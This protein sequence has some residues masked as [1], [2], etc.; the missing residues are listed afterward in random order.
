MAAAPP[1]EEPP[2]SRPRL[3]RIMSL[4]EAPEVPARPVAGGGTF[5][6]ASTSASAWSGTSITLS[7]APAVRSRSP[8]PSRRSLP[9]TILTLSSGGP[10]SRVIEVVTNL[11][12]LHSGAVMAQPPVSS[13]SSEEEID[14]LVEGSFVHSKGPSSSSNVDRKDSS[15]GLV[16]TGGGR[17]GRII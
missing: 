14:Q 1:K 2:C 9:P 13:A 6:K 3:T 8:V 4:E 5:R 17:M 16:A 10:S 11:F 12:R 7:L 15:L